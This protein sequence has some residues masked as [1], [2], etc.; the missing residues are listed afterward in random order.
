MLT[1]HE[2][3]GPNPNH[4][5]ELIDNSKQLKGYE[6]LIAL[7]D[8]AQRRHIDLSDILRFYLKKVCKFSK[9]PIGVIYFLPEKDPNVLVTSDIHFIKHEKKFTPTI[10]YLFK[11]GEDLAWQTIHQD[12]PLSDSL[13]IENKGS[14]ISSITWSYALPLHYHDKVIGVAQFFSKRN[15]Q[16][17]TEQLDFVAHATRHINMIIEKDTSEKNIK[18]NNIKLEAMLK[19]MKETQLQ[20]IQH[21]KIISIG[22]LAAG[23]AHEINNPISYVQNNLSSL[24]K[25]VTVLSEGVENYQKQYGQLENQQNI[26]FILSDIDNLFQE[27]FEGIQQVINIVSGLKSF[28]R[29]TDTEFSSC[30]INHC[31]ENSLQMARNELKYKCQVEKELSVLPP[32]MGNLN[33]LTQVFVNLLVNASQAIATKGIIQIK[34]ALEGNKVVIVIADNGCG[35]APKYLSKIFDPFF[36][37]KPIGIGTGLGLSISYG[38]IKDHGGSIHLVTQE[39]I[40]TTFTIKLPIARSSI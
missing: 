1:H 25:Y 14:I 27:S 40:G 19:K 24:K 7:I 32:V 22:Q 3:P 17:K 29:T 9:W 39:N 34:T 28:S 35:I 38:I 18:Y 26:E 10:K 2:S 16:D 30:D 33:Q 31:L 8:Y 13:V 21:S 23:M 20:L 4:P 5:I 12:R 15:H 37:T 6:L 11:K 36:T